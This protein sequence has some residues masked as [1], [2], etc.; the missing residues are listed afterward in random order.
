MH[1]STRKFLLIAVL[2]GFLAPAMNAQ[3]QI[4]RISGKI[5]D[6]KGQ[7][8]VG[9]L[10]V[11]QGMGN[12]VRIMTCKTNTRGDYVYLAGLLS[13]TY[14]IIVH[15]EGFTPAWKG[16][17]TPED[18]EA[19][20]E[21]FQLQPGDDFKTHWEME[22]QEANAASSFTIA[23]TKLMD[24]GKYDEAIAESNKA[25]AALFALVGESNLR[26]GKLEEAR[27][28]YEN[29]VKCQPEK[30]EY[31]A[32]LGVI[33]NKLGRSKEAQEMFKRAV[34]AGSGD[35]NLYKNYY[36]LGKRLFGAPQEENKQK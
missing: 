36:E 2:I 24:A 12:T 29:A 4:R 10:I 16:N 21:N 27:V 7:P 11:F 5:T 20:E 30:P 9:A 23:A 31:L 8:V 35:P 14:R 18:A 25:L 3:D 22:Y 34:K 6:D 19:K 17:I 33:L 1:I 13:V 32:N 15:K 26:L 28:A